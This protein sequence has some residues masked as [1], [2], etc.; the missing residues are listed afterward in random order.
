MTR[1]RR[2]RSGKG[3]FRA[4]H[5]DADQSGPGLTALPSQTPVCRNCQHPPSIQ[6]HSFAYSSINNCPYGFSI[7][8]DNSF[9]YCKL[10]R[11]STLT[12]SLVC[13]SSV[14]QV[15]LQSA[16]DSPP[17]TF[18]VYMGTAL[19]QEIQGQEGGEQGRPPEVRILGFVQIYLWLTKKAWGWGRRH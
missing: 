16:D 15:C 11:A 2:W 4:I 3:N 9:S 8:V 12:R 18:G 14:E 1:T 10:S 5:S 7:L 6:H 19:S 17:A 13:A